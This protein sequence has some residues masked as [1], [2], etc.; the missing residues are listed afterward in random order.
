MSLALVA[1]LVAFE[2]VLTVIEGVVGIP[3]LLMV[4]LREPIGE[5]TGGG[6][7][8]I[9]KQWKQTFW[10]AASSTGSAEPT[11]RASLPQSLSLPIPASA[12]VG[13]RAAAPTPPP[14]VV[15]QPVITSEALAAPEASNAALPATANPVQDPPKDLDLTSNPSSLEQPDTEVKPAP[16]QTL[17]NTKPT[18]DLPWEATVP[19]PLSE[20]LPTRDVKK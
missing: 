9:P 6:E 16:W 12:S 5:Q 8:V 1:G 17:R 14:V 4:Q 18:E 3:G 15:D 13:A 20:L 7:S 11:I 10:P 19:V 2:S